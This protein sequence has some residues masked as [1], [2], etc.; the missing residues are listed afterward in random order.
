MAKT[1]S[2]PPTLI[3]LTRRTLLEECCVRKGQHLLVAVSGGPDSMALL[4]VLGIL[5]PRLGFLLSAHG[6][7]H[8]LRPEA[9]EELALARALAADLGVPFTTS[10]VDLSPGGNLQA[11]ARALRYGAL[12]TAVIEHGA[13]LLLTAHHAEDR[14]ET[15]LIRLLRGS[16]PR[17]LAV[18]PAR[19]GALC[20]PL[21]RARRADIEAHLRRHG[22]LVARDPSNADRRFL[23]VR[24]R[25]ELLPLLETLSP[26]IVQHLNALADQ[27]AVTPVGPPIDFGAESPPAL[28]RAHLL[29]LCRARQQRIAGARVSLPGGREAWVDLRTGNAAVGEARPVARSDRPFAM[30]RK[31]TLPSIGDAKGSDRG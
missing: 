19:D 26:S 29:Q 1:R 18:L 5:R 27:M 4:H 3:T 25:A 21:I 24:V 22:L 6:V 11:R 13:E 16:G 7:D 17:G 10:R 14:A 12:S 8:G 9:A 15:V 23:R 31:K 2:H 30:P 20:R 28:S